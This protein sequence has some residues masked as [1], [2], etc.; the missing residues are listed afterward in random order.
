MVRASGFSRRIAALAAATFLSAG[1]PAVAQIATYPVAD[2]AKDADL[3]ARGEYLAKAAD[4]MPCH[5]GDKAKPFAGGLGLN[6]PFGM[7]YSPNITS[8]RSTGIGL[9]TYEQFV[10]AVR[11]GIRKDGAYLYPAMPFDAYTEISDDDMK[12]LWAFVRR[13]PPIPNTPPANGLEFP[14]N[15]RLGMLAWRELFFQNARFVPNAAKSAEWNRGAYLVNALGHCSDCH[16]PRN[17]MGATKGK[18]HFLGADVDGFWA[19]DI[20]TDA[21]MKDGWTVDTLS[22][23]LKTGSAPAKTSVFGPMAEVVHDSLGFLTDADR[24]AIVTYL[25]DSPRPAD[26]PAPQAASPLPAAVYT[27][28]SALYVDNCAVCHMDKGAGRGDTVPALAGNPAVVAVEPYNIIMAVLGGLPTGGTY[29]AMPSFA[30]RLDDQQIADLANYVRTSWGNT[31]A[32][33]VT[34]SMVASW[35]AT[36]HVPDYGTQAADAFT[37]PDVGG[38]PGSDGPDPKAVAAL[39]AM[40]AGGQHSIPMMV[41]AYKAASGS[42]GSGTVVD[43]LTAA[44]CPVVAKSDAP[45]WQKY[46]ELRRFTL[47]TAL[48]VSR[49]T[50]TGPV[51]SQP[52]AWALPVGPG[53]VLKEPKSLVGKLACPA[54]DGKAVPADLSAAATKLLGT[55]KPPM[56]GDAISTLATT[57]YQQN[58]KA[59]PADVANALIAAYCRVVVAEPNTTVADQNEL[60]N[61]FAGQAVQALQ[62]LPPRKVVVEVPTKPAAPAPAPAAAPAPAKKK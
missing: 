47:Q 26:V 32:P 49:R 7:I 56:A 39:S 18:A 5:T 24:A 6:T 23:F 13:I 22:V 53:L 27:R 37:C 31:A 16:T 61:G 9:W 28:A 48:E 58:P 42:A 20:A 59:P 55:P 50:I 11:N 34:A 1:A 29:G 4:C 52:I 43:A 8:D 62:L 38:A 2:A 12:A 45:T 30:G 21:L 46:A 44:Y 54:D 3:V 60:L 36:T 51:D 40:M 19:P 25:F 14:F 33:N 17:I 10:N 15:V 35:R 41:D 57:L